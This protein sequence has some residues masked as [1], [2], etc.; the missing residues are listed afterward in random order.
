MSPPL[1]KVVPLPCVENHIWATKFGKH[2]ITPDF[3]GFEDVFG[4]YLT[5][6]G[7]FTVL[8]GKF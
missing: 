4:L 7:S 5:N 6:T 2:N 3:I 1:L 8:L